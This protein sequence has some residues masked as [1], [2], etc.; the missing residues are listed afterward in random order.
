MPPQ[1]PARRP[2]RFHLPHDHQDARTSARIEA[3]LEGPPRSSRYGRPSEAQ[4]RGSGRPIVLDTNA[5]W[6]W[7]LRMESLRAERYGR[8]ATVLVID[9]AAAPPTATPTELVEPVLD[10]IRHEARETDRAVRVSPTRFH[11]LLPETGERDAAHFAT[12][13]REASRARLTGHG[14]LPRLRVEARTVGHAGT[15]EDALDEAERRLDY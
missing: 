6:R 14:E 10:A 11:V 3:F 13:L 15:L 7:A 4:R 12:R 5:E 2:R 8:P 9:V 1:R